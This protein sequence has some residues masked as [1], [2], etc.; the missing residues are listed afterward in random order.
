MTKTGRALELDTTRLLDL[1]YDWRAVYHAANGVE[2]AFALAAFSNTIYHLGNTVAAGDWLDESG[3][4][5][6]VGHAPTR[7]WEE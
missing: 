1:L 3:R 7:E 2:H 4:I 6:V 5:E